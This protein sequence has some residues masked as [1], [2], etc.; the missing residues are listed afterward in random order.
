MIQIRLKLSTGE[1]YRNLYSNYEMDEINYLLET[2][3]AIDLFSKKG[4]TY[5]PFICYT[6]DVEDI[7][8]EDSQR[9]SKVFISLHGNGNQYIEHENVYFHIEDGKDIENKLLPVK[10][11]AETHFEKM[12]E[13][14]SISGKRKLHL[15]QNMF[16]TS[17]GYVETKKDI[18]SMDTDLVFR[19]GVA[20]ILMMTAFVLEYLDDDE[21]PPSDE[22]IFVVEFCRYIRQEMAQYTFREI[23]HM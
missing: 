3:T 6:E 20:I 17:V 11:Y 4:N 21:L 12:L 13:P 9:V 8:M 16:S 23:P 2:E 7:V 18:S 1:I 5:I 15:I 19:Y 14:Y 22:N 10:K